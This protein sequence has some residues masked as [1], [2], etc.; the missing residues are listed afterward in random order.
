MSDS[1]IVTVGKRG[2][3]RHISADEREKRRSRLTLWRVHSASQ[4]LRCW[5]GRKEKTGDG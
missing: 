3:V 2:S 5:N 4:R 1:E